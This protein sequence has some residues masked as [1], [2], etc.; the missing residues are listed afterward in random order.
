MLICRKAPEI[1]QSINCFQA[2]GVTNAKD[3]DA[4]KKKVKELRAAI[5]R[6][7]KQQEKQQKERERLEK[8]AK[9]KT[10]VK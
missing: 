7:K 5:E 4:L 9:K 10:T 3:R 6:E 1:N 8:Q 2:L